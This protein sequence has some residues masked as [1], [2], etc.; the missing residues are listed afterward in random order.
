[1]EHN[2]YILDTRGNVKTPLSFTEALVK[3]LAQGGGLSRSARTF[4][5]FGLDE[6]IALADLPY[7][8]RAAKVYQAFDTDL[9]DE[10]IERLM[11]ATYG[12]ALEYRRHL[13]G[14]VA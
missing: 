13:S 5:S 1:M 11:E 8:Q 9:D 2:C 12:A 7:A 4:P 3:G 10:T 14:H 6:I